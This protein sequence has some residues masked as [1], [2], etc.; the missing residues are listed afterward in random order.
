MQKREEKIPG[1]DLEGEHKA[2]TRSINKW[3]AIADAHAI[4]G[5]RLIN[6]AIRIKATVELRE[7]DPNKGEKIRLSRVTVA[8]YCK[9]ADS[10]EAAE[11]K[12]LEQSLGDTELLYA[13]EDTEAVR[14]LNVSNPIHFAKAQR[15]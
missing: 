7:N 4:Q 15:I 5:S 2:T 12:L 13:A 9:Q 11:A 1:A 14:E 10:Q 6:V 3:K 8:V